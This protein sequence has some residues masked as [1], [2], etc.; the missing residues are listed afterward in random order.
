MSVTVRFGPYSYD[1]NRRALVMGILGLPPEPFRDGG[2]A[3]AF[4]ALLR[5]ADE[6]VRDGA[7]VL[8]VG[9]R[10]AGPGLAVSESE[11]LDQVVPP[12]AAL[13]ARVDVPLT[14]ATG[15]AR[16]LAA[17]LEAGAVV[18]LD[19]SG[20]GDPDYLDTAARRGASV[21][22]TH[23][24]PVARGRDPAPHD[25]DLVGEVAVFLL[26][27]AGRARAAGVDPDRI[28]L[29]AG[30]DLG[31]TAAQSAVLLRESGRLAGLGYPLLLSASN[32]TFLGVVLGRSTGELR[33]ASLS[34][35]A[36]GVARGCRIVRAHDVAGTVRV[37][38]MIERI[39]EVAGE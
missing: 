22:A 9:G 11:E 24:R 32:A 18:G 15:S 5:R 8:E 10:R 26:D 30:L 37:V 3:P 1:L 31:K 21:V 35:A 2:A 34:A 36:S 16:V 6:L 13:A 12:L 29:D 14:V 23:A 28:V 38:R 25:T 39:L 7:G 19:V 17:A 20:F 33:T 4:D 27:R